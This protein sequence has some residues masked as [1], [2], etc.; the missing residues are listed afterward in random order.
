MYVDKALG[1]VATVQ[2]LSR[3]NRKAKDDKQDTFI[4]DFVN[5]IEAIQKDFQNYYQTTTLGEATDSQKLYNLK[6]EIENADI[7][8]HDNVS[9][10][11]EMFVRKK[12]KSEVLSPFFRKIV[13][14]NYLHL[15]PEDKDIFRKN[16]NKYVRQY[17]FI[18]QIITFIDTELEK[19]YLFTKLLFKYL[20]YEKETLPLEITQM[21]DMDKFK[22]REQENNISITLNFEDA[23]LK[24]KQ[25][26]GHQEPKPEPTA[27]LEIIIQ[28]INNQYSINLSDDDKVIKEVYQTLKADQALISTLRANNIEDVK[29][30]KLRES[31][32][33]ALLKNAEPPLEL[34]N[35]LAKDKGLANY[36]V[37][38]FF[39]LLMSDLNDDV[40]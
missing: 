8:T 16:I 3:L 32:D 6:Y 22:I 27:A 19:F 13:D 38:Q 9:Y 34:L 14:E 18:S 1:G 5:D 7:F 36:V 10:F 33:D 25:G 12:V 37:S 31:L 26:D 30:I 17:S 28:E 29:K 39:Q 40:A 35:R 4:I 20:P 24:N 11:I 21:V 2:T 15:S 23:T